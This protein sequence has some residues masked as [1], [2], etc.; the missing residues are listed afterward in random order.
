KYTLSIDDNAQFGETLFFSADAG[1]LGAEGA[2]FEKATRFLHKHRHVRLGDGLAQGGEVTGGAADVSIHSCSQVMHEV[3]LGDL[4][5]EEGR[6]C[7]AGIALLRVDFDPAHLTQRHHGAGVAELV[8]GA[9]GFG[10]HLEGKHVD[11][12]RR[13]HLEEVL[14]SVGHVRREQRAGNLTEQV[15]E[16]GVGFYVLLE[17]ER[18]C[19]DRHLALEAGHENL[20]SRV[21]LHVLRLL[22]ERCESLLGAD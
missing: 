19:V 6:E 4:V 10:V 8:L 15:G 2:G 17:V 21:S 11:D 20:S 1:N 7:V 14:A 16:G 5:L 3:G 18:E 12:G 22:P 13:V 9:D